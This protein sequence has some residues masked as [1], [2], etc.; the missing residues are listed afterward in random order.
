[1]CLFALDKVFHKSRAVGYHGHCLFV[2]EF[3]GAPSAPRTPSKPSPK[4]AE[5]LGN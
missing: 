3:F 4:P 1:M 5:G 2:V